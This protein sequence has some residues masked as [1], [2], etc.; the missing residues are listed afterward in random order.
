MAPFGETTIELEEF[1]CCSMEQL[2]KRLMGMSAVTLLI[3]ALLIYPA[4]IHAF[5]PFSLH[6]LSRP[7]TKPAGATLI[8]LGD[9]SLAATHSCKDPSGIKA[10]IQRRGR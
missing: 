1:V 7:P 8:R 4:G 3:M 2:L 5:N 9:H 6:A 10:R